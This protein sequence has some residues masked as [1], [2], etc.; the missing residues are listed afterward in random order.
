MAAEMTKKVYVVLS[1]DKDRRAF[2]SGVFSDHEVAKSIVE[3]RAAVYREYKNWEKRRDKIFSKMPEYR[4]KFSEME[5][6]RYESALKLAIERAGQKPPIEV[7]EYS[8][9][10][11]VPMD[12]WVDIGC[13]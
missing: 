12:Q 9:I 5:N 13:G 10:I 11:E 3:E 1:E 7:A 2:I 8:E 4:I 6:N